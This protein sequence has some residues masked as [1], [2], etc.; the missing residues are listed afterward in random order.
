M[1]TD[2]AVTVTKLGKRIYSISGSR[3]APTGD[4]IVEF[5]ATAA[6]SKNG[7]YAF[8]GES[9]AVRQRSEGSVEITVLNRIAETAAAP[10]L[11]ESEEIS[12]VPGGDEVRF[13]RDFDTPELTTPVDRAVYYLTHYGFPEPPFDTESRPRP[14]NQF[15]WFFLLMPVGVLLLVAAR[16]IRRV[17]SKTPPQPQW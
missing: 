12:R 3:R 2:Y 14:T 4:Q 8:I 1:S 6:I 13:V 7:K 17:G 5:A 15:L 10:R 16:S 11:L 9:R